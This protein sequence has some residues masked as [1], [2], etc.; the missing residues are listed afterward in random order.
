MPKHDTQQAR[1]TAADL[2]VSNH[3]REMTVEE[4]HG[5]SHRAPMLVGMPAAVLFDNC[6]ALISI[7]AFALIAAF[8]SAEDHHTHPGSSD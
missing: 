1:I 5:A 8:A 6:P 2:P 3:W 4:P 7:E